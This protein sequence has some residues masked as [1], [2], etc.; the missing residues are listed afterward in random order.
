MSLYKMIQVGKTLKNNIS[1]MSYNQLAKGLGS[2][3]HFPYVKKEILNFDNYRQNRIFE[4]IQ[5]AINHESSLDIFTLEEVDNYWTFL[6][7]TFYKLGYD[8][9]YAKRPSLRNLG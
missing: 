3:E 7:N 9:T 4:Q 1:V 2:E 8:S 5:E 6:K